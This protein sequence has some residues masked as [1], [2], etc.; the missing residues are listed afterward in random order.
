MSPGP[1]EPEWASVLVFELGAVGS[2][3]IALGPVPAAREPTAKTASLMATGNA[4]RGVFGIEVTQLLQVIEATSI[5]PVPLAP[6]VVLGIM[7]FHGRIVTVVNPV[8]MLGLSVPVISGPE[9]RVLL[10]RHRDL[11]TGNVGLYVSQVQNIVPTAEL[12]QA[13]VPAGPCIKRVLKHGQRLINVVQVAPLLDGLVRE[14]GS[15]KG[16]E[17]RQGVV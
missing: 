17:P 8:P 3:G 9:S 13:E 2:S 6:A 5:S 1:K 14:F 11:S 16:R 4:Q 10:L 12:E 15:A 7:N